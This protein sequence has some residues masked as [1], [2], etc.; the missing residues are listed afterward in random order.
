[1]PQ[2]S[3]AATGWPNSPRSFARAANSLAEH[4]RSREATL[5]DVLTHLLANEPFFDYAGFQENP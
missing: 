2:K 1:M 5:R 3:P 4:L